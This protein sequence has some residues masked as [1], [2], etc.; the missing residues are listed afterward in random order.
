MGV[1][2]GSATGRGGGVGEEVLMDDGGGEGGKGVVYNQR[3][4]EWDGDEEGGV[5]LSREEKDEE[6]RSRVR[7]LR[8]EF[9]SFSVGVEW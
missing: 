5:S 8:K 4:D 2:V 9:P 6:E 7:E 3:G 1:V